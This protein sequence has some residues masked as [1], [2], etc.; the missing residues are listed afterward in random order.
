MKD[1]NHDTI[2]KLVADAVVLEKELII[3]IIIKS[4][5]KMLRIINSSKIRYL[6]AQSCSRNRYIK[7][8]KEYIIITLECNKHYIHINF[9]MLPKSIKVSIL[10]TKLLDRVQIKRKDQDY[11]NHN[12]FKKLMHWS[13]YLRELKKPR[14]N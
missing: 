6:Y 4:K 5:I 13:K 7:M 11:K 9:L 14:K 3:L 2:I 12:I 1:D 10:R 8:L